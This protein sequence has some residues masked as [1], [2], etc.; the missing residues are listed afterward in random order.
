MEDI[1]TKQRSKKRT[2]PMD[3]QKPVHAITVGALTAAIYLRQA[4][5]GF[6]Y[7]AYNLKRGYRSLTTGNQIQSTDFFAENRSDLVAVITE[8]SQWIASE[9]ERHKEALQT[10]A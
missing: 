10:A 7:Y 4:P 1:Q 6:S 8:A 5:S 3:A 2:A 9:S